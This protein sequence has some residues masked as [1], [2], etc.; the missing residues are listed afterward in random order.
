MAKSYDEYRKDYPVALDVIA[1]CLSHSHIAYLENIAL[2]FAYAIE[3][4]TLDLKDGNEHKFLSAVLV[5][6]TNE[7]FATI[8][9][10]RYGAL[11]ASHQHARSVLELY[12]ALEHVYC[13][14]EKRE[15]KLEKFVEYSN[16]ATYLHY[17]ELAN[18][19][20]KRHC[21]A[22]RI[23]AKLSGFG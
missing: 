14:P 11:L 5:K 10:L 1:E 19:L 15:R 2:R 6:A 23:C 18:A 16:V 22:R 4:K 7:M 13:T 12:A 20:V 3:E 9:S 8:G 21:D 17:Q